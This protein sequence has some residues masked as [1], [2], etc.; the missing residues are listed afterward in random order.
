MLI[1]MRGNV[2][3]LSTRQILIMAAFS[4][5]F[6]FASGGVDNAAHIGGLIGGFLAAVLLFH[7][8]RRS[9]DYS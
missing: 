7:P 2:E 4:L 9:W 5:Y 8:G 1:R 6:G 3:D